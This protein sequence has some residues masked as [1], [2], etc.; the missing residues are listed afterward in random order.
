M[1]LLKKG[2]LVHRDNIFD[3]NIT[4]NSQPNSIVQTTNTGKIADSFLNTTSTSEPNKILYTDSNGSIDNSIIRSS[5]YTTKSYYVN[6]I[7]G[8]DNNDGSATSPFQTLGKAF[9]MGCLNTV[10]KIYLQ[11]NYTMSPTTEQI[12]DLP[13]GRYELHF[14]N[15]TLTASIYNIEAGYNR[16]TTFIAQSGHVDLNLVFYNSDKIVIPSS[17]LPLNPLRNALFGV[18]PRKA[19]RSLCVT[20]DMGFSASGNQVLSISSGS[21]CGVLQWDDVMGAKLQVDFMPHYHRVVDL[22]GS[23]SYLVN[24]AGRGGGSLGVRIGNHTNS[25]FIRRNNSNISVSN[26]IAG[27]TYSSGIPVNITMAT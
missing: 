3:A 8:N 2:R 14:M 13:S 6:Q 7:S 24:F 22:Y 23:D 17:S 26:A 16:L 21:L 18:F 12:V 20:I 1:S 5:V 10:V 27:V 15:Y 19:S 4:T 9:S 25:S 11:S